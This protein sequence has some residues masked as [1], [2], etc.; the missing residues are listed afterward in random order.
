MKMTS[1]ALAAGGL[2]GL[3]AVV[4]ADMGMMGGGVTGG[5]MMGGSTL[6]H[7]Y[8]EKHGIDSQYAGKT[9]PLAATGANIQAGTKLFG[10]NCAACHGTTGRGDGVAAKGLN[11]PP[12]NL[13]GISR[14]HMT[15]DAYLDWTLSE[16][17]SALGSAM[18]AFKT[19]LTQKQIWQVIIYLRTL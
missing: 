2:L 19:V 14:M 4:Y 11:P 16:G 18:P 6:R 12:A 3:S 13:T 15:S 17:G 1:M 10:Q 7:Q 5:G 9:N 8:V